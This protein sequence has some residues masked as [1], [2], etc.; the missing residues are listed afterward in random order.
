MVNFHELEKIKELLS[1][2]FVDPVPI[3]G[4]VILLTTFL[5]FSQHDLKA[6]MFIIPLNQD[7]CNLLGYWEMWS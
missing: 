1:W 2:N 7:W 4:K 5:L 6:L 3:T